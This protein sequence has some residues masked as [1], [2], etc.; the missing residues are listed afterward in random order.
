MRGPWP[1]WGHSTA[2]KKNM[3]AN[4]IFLFK[5]KELAGMVE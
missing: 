2:G 5:L 4:A 1:A 3:T